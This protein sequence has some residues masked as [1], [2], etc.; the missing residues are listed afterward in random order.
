MKPYRYGLGIALLVAL[1]FLF[2]STQSV[3]GKV[4]TSHRS[5][6][7]FTSISPIIARQ[8]PE[9]DA[10]LDPIIEWITFIGSEIDDNVVD[11]AVDVQG[12]YYFIGNSHAVEYTYAEGNNEILVWKMSPAGVIIWQ[13][14]IPASPTS[15]GNNLIITDDDRIFIAGLSMATWGNPIEPFHGVRDAFLA[16]IDENG[17]ILWHTFVGTE[18][19]DDINDVAVNSAGDIYLAFENRDPETFISMLTIAKLDGSGQTQWL[20]PLNTEG[21]GFFYDIVIAPNGSIFAAGQSYTAWGEPIHPFANDADGFLAKIDSEGTLIWH[22]F[23]GGNGEDDAYRILLDDEGNI[24]SCGYSNAPW[25]DPLNPHTGDGNFDPYIAKTDPNGN[26]I[27]HTFF[28]AA[29]DDI[30]A[31]FQYGNSGNLL[32]GGTSAN[33]WGTPLNPHIGGDDVFIAEV[34]LD[35]GLVWNTFF[36]SSGN[37]FL[38]VLL[39]LSESNLLIGGSSNS[40]FGNPGTPP[41]GSEDAFIANINL[42][43]APPVVVAPPPQVEEPGTYRASGP[44]VPEI[45]RYIP[46]PQDVSTKPGVVGNNILAAVFLMLP[47]AVAVDLFTRFFDENETSLV[48]RFAFVAMI[49]EL[50]QRTKSFFARMTEKGRNVLEVFGIIGV[51]F[52]YGLV[53]SLLDEAWNPFTLKGVLLFLEMIVAYGIVGIL[54][55]ILQWRRI[56]KWQAS[57]E[58]SIR[59][60]NIFLALASLGTSRVL[61]L[62]PGLMFG[63]PEAL[64]VDEEKLTKQQTQ[65]LTRISSMTYLFT[66]IGAWGLTSL[67]YI[68]KERLVDDN[69]LAVVGG[70]E[71]FLLIVF[72]VALENVFVQLLGISDGLGRKLKKRNSWGWGISLVSCA[73][74]F[75]HTLLNPRST[76]IES[77]QQGNTTLF[78]AVTGSFIVLTFA[79]FFISRWRKSRK[80]AKE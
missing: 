55:D 17:S 37:D 67:T 48:E 18:L 2:G 46:A 34:D 29:G 44:Y 11:G 76:F 41:S 33:T 15:I 12:N 61:S 16:E 14:S 79:V 3:S 13:A 77:L 47:F 73:F 64:K 32:L 43:G 22:T 68:L 31:S 21:D 53:F 5:N 1:I 71:A 60:T 4:N 25:G 24:Y 39:P 40:S 62:L 74:V 42:L 9:P 36:G 8:T 20:R 49:N 28:G 26:L 45:T 66:C 23:M 69:A 63:S 27:W 59:P 72:A 78:I 56:R 50:Q 70:F 58:L 51:M 38:R 10:G 35:G 52:F 6:Q 19:E 30:D 65:T 75:L 57:A 7:S 80:P 54:D